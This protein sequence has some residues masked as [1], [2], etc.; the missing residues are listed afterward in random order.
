[1]MIGLMIGAGGADDVA[2][3]GRMIRKLR[4]HMSTDILASLSR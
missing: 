3:S 1:M 2:A 4:F